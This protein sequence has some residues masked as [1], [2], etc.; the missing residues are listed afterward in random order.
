MHFK[1]RN[2]LSEID[3]RETIKI[4]IQQENIK[5]YFIKL[6]NIKYVCL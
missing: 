4:L 6:W 3:K 5:L 2:I 1:I